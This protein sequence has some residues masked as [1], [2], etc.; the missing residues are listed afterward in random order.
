MCCNLYISDALNNY[1]RFFKLPRLIS[2][3]MASAYP[4]KP[5]DPR[6]VFL[7]RLESAQ[8]GFPLT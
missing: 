3:V 2:T 8:V 1:R 6:I 7:S 4:L 5:H